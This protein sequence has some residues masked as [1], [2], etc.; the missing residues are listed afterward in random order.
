MTRLQFST[1]LTPVNRLRLVFALV[2]LVL[3]LLWWLTAPAP[4]P[5]LASTRLLRALALQLTGVLAIGT[6][7]AVL[8]LAARPGWVEPWLG[9]LDKMYRL[10]KWLGIAALAFAVAHW[11]AA[12]MPHQGRGLPRVD[13]DALGPVGRFLH[14]QHDFAVAAGAYA[15]YAFS[16]LVVLALVKRFPYRHFFKTHRLLAPTFLVLAFHAAALLRPESWRVPLGPALAA[17]LAAGGAA[18][19]LVL[20]RRVGASRRA[21]GEVVGIDR[22]DPLEA[23]ELEI[24]LRGRWGG[25]EAGQFAFLTLDER[26]GPHPFTI[27]SAWAGD[28][29][30]R[31]IIKALGDYTRTIADHVRLG[32]P[33]RIEGPYG[34]FTFH[35]DAPRQIWIGAGVGVAPFVARMKDLA[36]HSDGKPVDLYHTTKVLEPAAIG[37]LER[38][39]AAAGV[40]LHVLWDPRDGRLD[41]RRLAEEVPGWREAEIWFCGPAAF[42]RVL[43]RELRARGLPAGRF[44]QELFELR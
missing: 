3:G 15:F 32:D 9:G 42:G 33:V 30:I 41:A 31:F 43:E 5:G 38:D 28:G 44:H 8:V 6:M 11:L 27:S 21:E 20:G 26:E 13:P 17:L 35:D 10:H 40:R 22:H 23:L 14:G 36:R 19:L 37:L 4:W 39:A 25:H 1:R 18:A 12:L 24:Q 29:R 7:A 2:P 16:L 34:A